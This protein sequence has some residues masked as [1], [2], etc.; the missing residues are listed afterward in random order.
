[1]LAKYA[2]KCF[3][4]WIKEKL[5]FP[6]IYDIKN[7][8]LTF[9]NKL[10]MK[11]CDIYSIFLFTMVIIISSNYQYMPIHSMC[12]TITG[13]GSKIILIQ[14]SI[15]F[16]LILD[17]SLFCT[18]IAIFVQIVSTLSADI[19]CFSWDP[20]NRHIFRGLT[21]GT[22]R[23]HITFSPMNLISHSAQDMFLFYLFS[24]I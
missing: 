10:V 12:Q 24:Q 20:H 23:C 6:T 21:S 19:I 14:Y 9:L 7:K 5:S 18:N 4:I 17:F 16:V 11:G 1:M 22:C 2:Q 13:E 15:K 3:L 8:T